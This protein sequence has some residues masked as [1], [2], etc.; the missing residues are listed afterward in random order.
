MNTKLLHDKHP[1]PSTRAMVALGDYQPP[2]MPTEDSLRRFWK[3]VKQRIKSLRQSKSEPVLPARKFESATFKALDEVAGPPACG[4]LLDDFDEAVS[5]WYTDPKGLRHYLVVLPPCDHHDVIGEWALL[6][7]HTVLDAPPRHRVHEAQS[8]R[9][10]E[11]ENDTLLVIPKL[12]QWFLRHRNGLDCIK[13]LFA[14]LAD[15]RHRCVIG[16][17]SWAWA[18]LVKSAGAGLIL[19]QP[20]S[21]APFDALRLQEWFSKLASQDKRGQ[22]VFRLAS[23]GSDALQKN[24]DGHLNNSYLEQ[25][26]SHSR[27]IPW[28]AWHKWRQSLRTHLDADAPSVSVTEKDHLTL[29]ITEDEDASLPIDL[30]LPL[31]DQENGLLV[32]HALLMHGALS[33]AELAAVLPAPAGTGLITALIR[34]GFIEKDGDFLVP[35]AGTYPAMRS[36]LKSAGFPLGR[37]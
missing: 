28:V 24:D 14:E 10:P 22:V 20:M 32:L 17:N 2:A 35:Q 21:F 31:D 16:C 13:A 29:W 12:E 33:S 18:F 8:I 34:A 7:G 36:A 4:P 19:P 15:A 11:A 30:P 23:N 6:R 9:F 3:R 26:A 5:A 27:G 37:I 25:L 1:E